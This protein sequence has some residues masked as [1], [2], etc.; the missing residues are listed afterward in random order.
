MALTDEEKNKIIEEEKLRLKIRLKYEQKSS[1]L[2]GVLSS[3][4]PGLGQIY[5][6]QFWKATFIGLSIIISI[7]LLSLGITFW[8]KGVP[9]KGEK[10]SITE[11]KQVE[12]TE[13][14]VVIEEEVEKNKGKKEEK[15]ESK[16]KSPYILTIL[17]VIGL[18]YTWNYAVKDAIKTSQ[19]LNEQAIKEL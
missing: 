15:R 14:G 19:K 11:E 18:C 3:I 7:V 13:E 5:N 10:V 2:S 1:G 16:P 8:V 17:G 9:Q 12:M 4:C 6:G